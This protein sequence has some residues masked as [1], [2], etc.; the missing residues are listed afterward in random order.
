[1]RHSNGNGGNG[2]EAGV[3]GSNGGEK[4]G[5]GASAA[6][7]TGSRKKQ[8]RLFGL[9]G[10]KGRR[11]R[12]TE[13]FSSEERGMVDGIKRLGTHTVKDI[14]VPRID[15]V[16]ISLDKDARGEVGKIVKSGHSRFPVYSGT[17]DNVVGII[18]VKDVMASIVQNSTGVVDIER[19]MRKPY[20]V[21]D[22]KRLD[23]LMREMKQRRVHIAIVVDEYGGVSGL[24]CLEDV[25]EEIVGEIRDEFDNEQDAIIS[26][27][28]DTYLCDARVSIKE[29][30][31]KLD[32]TLPNDDFDTL[33][34]Y[35]FELFG[36][37]PVRYEKQQN[38][39]IEFIIQ[40]MRGHRI[41]AIKMI[42][43]RGGIVGGGGA[44]GGDETS[45][46]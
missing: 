1:M 19:I 7:G 39:G 32:L 28:E 12:A 37:I 29:L 10:I 27:R 5:N 43:D 36:K 13:G 4:N 30:N 15:S 31:E 16:F 22:S 45:G 18:Y 8:R 24:A 9:F 40:E 33:G 3:N 20:F 26:I 46:E 44:G 6:G 42:I 34:G 11:R 38:N 25:I 41:E 17:I 2:G 35:V 23:A 21:P 14:L